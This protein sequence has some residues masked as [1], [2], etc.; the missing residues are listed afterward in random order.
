M[1]E[2]I[3]IRTKGGLDGCDQGRSGAGLFGDALSYACREDFQGDQNNGNRQVLK[4]VA[5]DLVRRRIWKP[6]AD[7]PGMSCSAPRRKTESSFSIFDVQSNTRGG[8]HV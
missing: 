8:D 2:D 1:A 5:T 4:M 6:G 7:K 3:S